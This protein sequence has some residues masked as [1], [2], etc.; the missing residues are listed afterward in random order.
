MEEKGLV[1]K[2][3]GFFQK[4]RKAFYLNGMNA[5]KASKY[6]SL[7]YY[8]REDEDVLNAIIEVSEDMINYIP[9]SKVKEVVKQKP[10]L[11]KKIFEIKVLNQ[12]FKENPELIVHYESE[13]NLYKI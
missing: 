9:F 2:K 1:K 12:I 13:D 11:L 4:I 5:R 7:P 10:H 3:L 6:N 8:L